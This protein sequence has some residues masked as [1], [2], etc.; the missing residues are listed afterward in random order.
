MSRNPPPKKKEEKF[1]Y[2]NVWILKPEIKNTDFKFLT[3][4]RDLKPEYA[5]KLPNV[6][7]L[8]H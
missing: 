8:R 3:I 1:H 6:W 7:V 4:F 2:Q 5:A